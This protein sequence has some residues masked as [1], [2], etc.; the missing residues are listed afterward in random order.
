MLTKEDGEGSR[1]GDWFSVTVTS[2]QSRGDDRTLLQWCTGRGAAP[3]G[4][5]HP[6][7]A[8]QDTRPSREDGGAT[9][10]VGGSGL[11][12]RDAGIAQ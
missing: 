9:A 8:G 10:S 7:T 2:T 6:V 12:L 5:S 11:K 3:R 4:T 1:V